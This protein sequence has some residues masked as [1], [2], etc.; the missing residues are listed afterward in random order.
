[1]MSPEA[2]KVISQYYPLIKNE[3]VPVNGRLKVG[4]AP[5]F[6]VELNKEDT[7]LIQVKK[8]THL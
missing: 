8:G 7:N 6:G 3:P 2:D 4:D 5:G 1:M